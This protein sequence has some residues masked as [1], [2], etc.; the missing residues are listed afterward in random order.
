MYETLFEIILWFIFLKQKSKYK[1][2]HFFKYTLLLNIL[3]VQLRFP[4]SSAF[5]NGNT[6]DSFDFKA[7]SNLILATVTNFSSDN[8]FS[9]TFSD[10]LSNKFTNSNVNSQELSQ[11]Y[12]NAPLFRHSFFVSAIY[13]V[14]YLIVFIIGLVGN[15]FVMIVVIRSNRMRNATNFL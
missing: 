6:Y 8:N 5:K 3:F 15:C 12:S 9:N 4:F 11:S 2:V 7:S 1:V 10:T 13:L 14:A